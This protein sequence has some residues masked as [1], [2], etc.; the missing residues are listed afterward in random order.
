MARAVQDILDRALNRS[1]ANDQALFAGGDEEI[2]TRVD[3]AQQALFSRLAEENRYFYVQPTTKASN[4]AA[5]NRVVDL[6]TL[7]PPVE[8]LLLV[9]LPT[10]VQLS[11]VDLQDLEAE[12]APRF[13]PLGET[14]VEVDHDWGA[15]GA[16]TLSLWYAYRPAALNLAGDLTQTVTVPDRFCG[17]LEL[18]LAIYLAGKDFG[19]TSVDGSEIARL[20]AEQTQVFQDFLTFLDH[21]AGPSSRRFVLPVPAAGEK[22]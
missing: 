22:S 21:F 7:D 19:R 10:G 16:I 8:R 12:L 2:L 18:E 17:W 1:I 5:A 6:S 13:Y 14:L 3:Y 15:T 4:V 11:Q 9:K 20:T